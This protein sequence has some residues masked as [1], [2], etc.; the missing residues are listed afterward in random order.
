MRNLP[1]IDKL[2]R[3]PQGQRMRELFGEERT[4][5][6]LRQVTD[7]LRQRLRN[8]EQASEPAQLILEQ[9]EE[10]LE[11]Q[12]L[13]SLR[14]V[15]NATGVILHTNLGRAPLAEAAL[16]QIV[17]TAAGYCNVELDL[18]SGER[19]SRHSHVAELLQ[20]LT[21]AEAS[22]VVNNCAAAMMLIVDELARGKEVIVSRGELVEIGGAF[23]VPDV[24][25]RGGARLIEVG[26]TNKTRIADF[27]RAVTAETAMVLST[28]LSNFAMTGFVESPT[29][30]ELT[31]LAREL[32][33]ISCLDL[34]SGLLYP[35]PL[36]AE[37]NVVD[38][39]AQGFDLVA[40][41]GDKLLGATQAGIILGKADLIGRLRKNPLMRALRPDKL[42][43]AALEATLRLYR[44]PVRA[45]QQVPVL[46]MIEANLDDLKGRAQ[47]LSRR[48]KKALG[49]T[50]L[51]RVIEGQSSVGGGS[52]PGGTLPSWLVEVKPIHVNEEVWAARLRQL[53]PSV[54]VRR[55]QNALWL[56]VRTLCDEDLLILELAFRELN[57]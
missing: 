19:G 3:S 31:E 14:P 18:E 20:D 35:H 40:F 17:D 16:Q 45:R 28:H 12:E 39:L 10:T 9:A 6:V 49:E 4:T 1:S 54:L 50:A 52:L 24:L 2:Q 44:D 8:G 27:R 25:E 46:A 57:S 29:P 7:D 47:R 26:T 37:P 23:R 53:R 41:S 13:P 11:S 36:L 15:I 30:N 21:G 42:S 43:L 48:L 38:S 34:G 55:S 5:R 32:G 22:V 56:D 33:L 51:V